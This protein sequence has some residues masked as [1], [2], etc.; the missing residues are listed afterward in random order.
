VRKA[1]GLIERIN[2]YVHEHYSDLLDRN[3]IAGAFHLAPEYLAKLYKKKTGVYLK[4]YIREYRVEQAKR[5]LRDEDVLISDVAG[6]VGFD[7]FSYFSTIFRKY[8][9]VTPNEYRRGD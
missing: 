9:G 7:N 6:A 3:E 8:V 2:A 4:D 5:L 1:S